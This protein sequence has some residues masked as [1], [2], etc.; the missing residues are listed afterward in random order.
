MA[1]TK[2]KEAY[3]NIAN[4][5]Q[6]LQAAIDAFGEVYETKFF[7]LNEWNEDLDECLSELNDDMVESE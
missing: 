2:Q 3:A 7:G 6:E 5:V 1:T 4:K